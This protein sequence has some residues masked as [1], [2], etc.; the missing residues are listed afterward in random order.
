M[1]GR[2]KPSHFCNLV[3]N[4]LVSTLHTRAVISTSQN[5]HGSTNSY[6]RTPKALD[7]YSC[8][9][10]VTIVCWPWCGDTSCEDALMTQKSCQCIS[11]CV[12]FVFGCCCAWVW[13]SSPAM[14][15]VYTHNNTKA[16]EGGETTVA[17]HIQLSQWYKT[18]NRKVKEECVV[19]QPHIQL[20]LSC[21]AWDGSLKNT[22]SKWCFG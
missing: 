15:T 9:L 6:M 10:L 2:G 16:K 14:I 3:S 8:E 22:R 11:D 20:N 19:E 7:K 18:E 17:R 21:F 4:R 13:L 5:Q 1:F 12:P